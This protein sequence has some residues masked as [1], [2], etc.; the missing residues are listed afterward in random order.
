MILWYAPVS[1]VNGSSYRAPLTAY[2]N[3]DA[4]CYVLSIFDEET[5]VPFR[6]VRMR[7]SN[8]PTVHRDR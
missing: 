8:Q 4:F 3:S 2:Y 5:C 7:S 6:R 1:L